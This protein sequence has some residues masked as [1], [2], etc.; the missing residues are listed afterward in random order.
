MSDLIQHVSDTSV[1]VA[2]YRAMESEREDSLFKDPFAKILV[3]DRSGEFEKMK[4]EATKWTRWT[5]VIRT[6]I[7]DRM[8][9][10]L[11]SKR[12][13]TFVNLGAGLDSRPYRLNLGSQIQ[14]IEVD[15]PHVIEH[16]RSLLEKFTPT[17]HLERV[18][19]DLSKWEA[20][21]V[22]FKDLSAKY[23]N[24]AVLTE[25]VLPYLTES[26]VAELSE[27]LTA[28]MGFRY[29]IGE[30]LSPKSYRYLKDPKRMKALKNAPFS[31]YPEDWM[32]FFESRGWKLS[33][34]QYFTEV[35]EYLGRPSPMP[36][37]FKILEFVFGKKW[38]LPFKRMSGFLLWE[39]TK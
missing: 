32:G 11:I 39:R 38:A 25:G 15:F 14:W 27:D 19:L 37:F 35:S 18:G 5:V 10:D 2:H 1:W 4:S 33:Q 3:G 23:S 30:Y 34:A 20:R 6:Y 36:K 16:K 29:W 17:C 31:F 28:H 22:L 8:I 21:Q 7:I 13:T 24:I 12:V 26:Q 9:Q